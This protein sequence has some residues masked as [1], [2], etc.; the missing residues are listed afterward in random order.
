M[1]AGAV[2]SAFAAKTKIMI[3]GQDVSNVVARCTIRR[4][5]EVAECVDLTLLIDRLTVDRDGTLVIHILET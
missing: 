3:A 1:D 2:V 4:F 5:P